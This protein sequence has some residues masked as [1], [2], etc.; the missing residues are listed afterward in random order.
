MKI[1]IVDDNIQII[2]LLSGLLESKGYSNIFTAS[3]G[4]EGFN[5]FKSLQPDIILTDIE[6]P[7]MD[8]LEMLENIRAINKKVIVII[9]SGVGGEEKVIRALELHANNFLRKPFRIEFVLSLL[10]KYHKI[11]EKKSSF[12]NFEKMVISSCFSIS[13]GNDI[14]QIPFLVD[15]LLAHC[16]ATLHDDD[17]VKIEFGLFELLINAIEHGNLDISYEEKTHALESSI[18]DLF[19]LRE[20]RSTLEKYKDRKVIIRFLM[21]KDFFEWTIEDSGDGFNWEGLK[22]PLAN[23]LLEQHGRGIF[24]TRFQFDELEYIGNGNLVRARTYRKI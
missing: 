7:G 13:Y 5:K 21:N 11:H 20:K 17:I 8:G 12:L 22:S 15:F 16:D 23:G 19:E 18:D 10:D 14:Q 4:L 24:L 3:N 1:L 9:I 6:M 2:T